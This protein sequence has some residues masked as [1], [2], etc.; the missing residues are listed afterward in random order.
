MSILSQIIAYSPNKIDTETKARSLVQGPRNMYN[1]GQLVQPNADGLRPGYSGALR[2]EPNITKTKA[3][4][5]EV[6]Y[7]NKQIG[8]F[9]K[10]S[11]ARDARKTAIAKDP[12]KLRTEKL[13]DGKISFNSVVEN[14]MDDLLEEGYES[15]STADINKKLS[16]K[17]KKDYNVTNSKILNSIK[18]VRDLNL[19]KFKN[20]E[21]KKGTGLN[22]VKPL[23]KTRQK[24]LIE[25]F[26]EINFNF[27]E[28]RKYGIDKA[29]NPERWRKIK[30]FAERGGGKEFPY[31]YSAKDGL[32]NS[33]YRSTIVGDRWKLIGEAP[34]NWKKDG[35]WKKTKFKDTK[36]GD[37]ITYDNLKEY[38][39]SQ[40]GKGTYENSLKSWE[41]KKALSNIKIMYQG[42]EQSL[43]G[44]LNKKALTKMGK[45]I[46][47]GM[48][49]L[50]GFGAFQIAHTKGVGNNFWDVEVAYRDANQKLNTLNRSMLTDLKNVDNLN[51]KN[52]IIKNY[53]KQIKALPGGASFMFEGQELGKPPTIKSATEAAFKD[54]GLSKTYKANQK[55]IENAMLEFAGTITD[56]CKVGNAEGGRI[57][58]KTGSADCLR[59]AK[60]GMDE[61]LST[62]KWKS[63][64]QAKIARNIAETAGKISKTGIGARVM[65]ELFGPVAIASLPVFEA[66]IAGYDTITSGTPFNEAI[67][68]TLLHYALGDKT[69]A[70]PE[71]LKQADILKMSDGPEKEMLIG[72]YSNIGN[73][74]RVMN[75]YKQ[76]AGLEQDKELYEAVDIMG[77]GDKGASATQAQKQIE[78][79]NN[80]ILQDRS[81]GKDYMTLSRAVDDPYAKGLAES[82]EG[83]LLA[84]RDANSLSS[85]LFG[86]TN[87]YYFSSNYSGEVNPKRIE[88]MKAKNIGMGD[89]QLYSRDQVVNFLKTV[90]DMEITDETVDFLQTKLNADYFRNVL[91]QPGMLGT[92]Y[93]EGGIASLNVK[94]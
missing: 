64:D 61:G 57:G 65:A 48:K 30:M 12:G 94:K 13:F 10:I 87:P 45:E 16:K 79:I 41:N 89:S 92:Q 22:Q 9:N 20:F 43:G 35:V 14:T 81:Q 77:Y 38:V 78:A 82:K 68:K 90:P 50:P 42:K 85:R 60:E 58:F 31:G 2:I 71:K 84:K 36:T 44:V 69:K 46:P 73:L 62:G 21:F 51:E 67:N 11:D 29:S 28:G 55:Q 91:N 34:D 17:I 19:D 86:T 23:T 76:K 83:E 47:S 59:I 26:P 93:S 54:L 88:E 32:W 72:L 27:N 4:N 33:V 37:I 40:G 70:D 6:I 52:K 5:Y 25:A 80:K 3:G 8:T 18:K 53:S 75:N 39:D 7:K 56:K 24:Y 15:Y 63:P 49:N 74:N 66:G 1:Q